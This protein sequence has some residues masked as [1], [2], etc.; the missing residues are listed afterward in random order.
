MKLDQAT[1]DRLRELGATDDMLLWL[2]HPEAVRVLMANFSVLDGGWRT[3]VSCGEEVLN[4]GAS[5]LRRC[6]LAQALRSLQH[7]AI[8]NDV[9]V[10]HEEALMEDAMRDGRVGQAPRGRG[11]TWE[12]MNQAMIDG[13]RGWDEQLRDALADNPLLSLVPK[14]K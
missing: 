5:H 9:E 8:E 10:A 13:M 2:E 12:E 11:A 1:T 3:C 6:E 4:D 14:R 7:P